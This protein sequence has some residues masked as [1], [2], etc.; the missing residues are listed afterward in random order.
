[1]P[2]PTLAL[3]ATVTRRQA[4]EPVDQA[5]RQQQAEHPQAV[6]AG[7]STGA[8]PVQGLDSDKA[9]QTA[10]DAA[11]VIE[12]EKSG[13]DLTQNAHALQIGFLMANLNKPVAIFLVNGL[14]LTGKLRQFDQFKLLLEGPDG[15]NSLIFKSALTTITPA[16]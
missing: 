9:R 6:T 5:E 2:K 16:C 13:K 11:T 3:K 12:P 10:G 14:R 1:M 8:E 7:A 4:A 15:L